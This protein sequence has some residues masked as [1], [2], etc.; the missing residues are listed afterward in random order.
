[1]IPGLSADKAAEL[2]EALS[3]PGDRSFM[4]RLDEL[5]LPPVVRR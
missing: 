1:M 5:L 3:R 2:V 4:D